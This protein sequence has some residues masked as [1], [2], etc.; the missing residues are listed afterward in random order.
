[1]VAASG[2]IGIIPS[3]TFIGSLW[4]EIFA[5]LLGRVRSKNTAI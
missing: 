1:L 2:Y 5:A 3:R 4:S